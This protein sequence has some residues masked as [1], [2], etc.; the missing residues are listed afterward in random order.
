MARSFKS[1]PKH[2][3]T[4]SLYYPVGLDESTIRNPTL[5]VYYLGV[6]SGTKLECEGTPT[7]LYK[8]VKLKV[9]NKA[10]L[11]QLYKR[12]YNENNH[13]FISIFL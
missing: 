13:H 7:L 4:V 9:I 12:K 10:E 6:M 5:S 1:A 8:L 2:V 11:I 3:E